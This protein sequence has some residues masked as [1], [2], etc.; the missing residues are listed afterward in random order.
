MKLLSGF[1]LTFIFLPPAN[2]ENLSSCQSS[3]F[4][5]KRICNSTKPYFNACD[6]DLFTCKASC[7]S[8]KP[9][10]VYENQSYQYRL[11]SYFTS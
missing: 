7:N 2:A 1:I 9:Q 11:S 10:K 8:G 6:D 3:C 5:A 4:E